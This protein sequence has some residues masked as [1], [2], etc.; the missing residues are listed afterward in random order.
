[1]SKSYFLFFLLVIFC[2]GCKKQQAVVQNTIEFDLD[3]VHHSGNISDAYMEVNDTGNISGKYVYLLS[4]N[5]SLPFFGISIAENTTPHAD[6]CIY[7]GAYDNLFATTHCSNT[8]DSLCRSFSFTYTDMSL[9]LFGNAY[10]DSVSTFSISSCSGNP[11][12][13]NGTFTCT[14]MDMMSGTGVVK[15]VTNG[16]IHN[17]QYARH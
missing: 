4:S 16:K 11:S 7:V 15:H 14:L 2:I 10:A 13:I 6:N 3:G 8:P 5:N 9:G 17:V 12:V 1:M